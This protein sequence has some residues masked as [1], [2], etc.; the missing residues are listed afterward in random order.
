MKYVTK[1]L[2]LQSTLLVFSLNIFSCKDDEVAEKIPVAFKKSSVEAN[3]NAKA[4]VRLELSKPA[5]KD[6]YVTLKV[7]SSTATF[8]VDY[9]IDN[10]L[11][12]ERNFTVLVPKDSSGASFTIHALADFEAE[13][14]EKVNFVIE[15]TSDGLTTG[16]AKTLLATIGDVER[17]P[18]ANRAISFDGV[19]DYI[20]LGNI[21]DDL[22]LP[23]SISVWV[24]IDPNV[25]DGSLPIFD[26]QDGLPLYNGFSLI[27]SNISH[28][29]VQYG[30]GQGENSSVYRRARSAE[31]IPVTGRWVNMTGVMRAA[32]DMNVYLNG[33]EMG[34]YYAGESNSSMNS[35]SP[36]ENAKVGILSNNG[37]TIHFQGK[38]DEL[39]IWN[40]ALTEA[41]IQKSII[42]K[43]TSVDPGLVG[44]WDFNEAKGDNVIDKS[45][46]KFNGV[47]KGG[48]TRVP[49]EAPVQ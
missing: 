31:F 30:D 3:E 34:G 7:T 25:A 22:Q 19:D 4:S 24:W 13:V 28:I 40:R 11:F 39:R 5:A 35:N 9:G 43:A 15:G 6:E 20:D 17:Y 38:L 14:A 8:G 1:S 18:D 45:S 23:V 47:L 46:N 29:G 12:L 26:S 33:V 10:L 16:D 48:A 42:T 32:S 44:Y 21:L 27:T 37:R 41:E 49:S 36:N 2:L